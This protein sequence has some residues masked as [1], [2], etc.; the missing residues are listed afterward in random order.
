[1]PSGNLFSISGRD[2]NQK[3]IS[4]SL[5]YSYDEARYY[6]QGV[7][8]IDFTLKIQFDDVNTLLTVHVDLL[9]KNVSVNLSLVEDSL[10]NCLLGC[11][12]KALLKPL[13]ECFD[14]N[15]SK[16]LECIRSKGLSIALNIVNCAADCA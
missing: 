13:I 12:A 14:K 15:I 16:Y 7:R 8:K 4:T 5:D 6:D 9:D 2:R 11:A 10:T 1:M 3:T